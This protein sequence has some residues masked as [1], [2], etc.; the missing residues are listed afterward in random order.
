M[1]RLILNTAES[2]LTILL[3]K[4]NKLFFTFLNSTAHHNETMLPEIDKLLKNHKLTINDIEEFGVVV[5]PGSF[6]GIRVGVATVKAFRDALNVKAKG[7]NNLDLL[8][9]LAVSQN[10]KIDTVAILGSTDSYFVA[11]KINDVVYKYERNLTLKELTSLTKNPI[12]MYA[13]GGVENAYIVKFDPQIMLKTYLDSNDYSLM[14]VYYQLSQA[15]REKLKKGK[16]EFKKFNKT[17]TEKLIE[18]ET[19]SIVA[20]T[21]SKQ[22][23]LDIIKNK[24]YQIFV[25]KFNG[26]LVGYVITQITD[27]VNI[28]SIAVKREFRN[29]GIGTNLIKKVENFAKRKELNTISLEVSKTNVTAYLLYQKCGFKLRRV[30]KKYYSDGSD[31]FEMAKQI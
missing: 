2:N 28:V 9:N 5:G 17:D 29:F 12:G 30:R 11:K 14:P 15:E 19:N 7:I 3:E 24:N 13:E 25:C 31:C 8:F 10:N 27:E 22:E 16:F 18:I 26:E 4:E 23:I 21:L 20:N 1:K 6:T